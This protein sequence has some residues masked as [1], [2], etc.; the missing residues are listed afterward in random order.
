MLHSPTSRY[1]PIT[2]T[3]GRSTPR[4]VD[5]LV[6]GWERG[7]HSCVDLTGVS[8]L[9]GLRDTGFVAGQVV[10]KAESGKV[11]K[12]ENACLENQNVFTPFAFDTFGFL[13]PEAVNFLNRAQMGCTAYT[14]TI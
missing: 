9:V 14:Y 2:T 3:L 11:A 1:N 7:K 5:I 8:P 12:H 6:F 13:A 10:L 4:P